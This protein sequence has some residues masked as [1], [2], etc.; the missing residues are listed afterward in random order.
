MDILIQAISF[1]IIIGV[2]VSVHEFGHFI[3][4]KWCGVGVLKFSIGFGRA[5]WKKTYKETVYQI[6]LIPLGGFVRM[7]GDMPDP[8]TTNKATDDLVREASGSKPSKLAQKNSEKEKKRQEEAEKELNDLSRAM[9]AD[10][11]CW[12][13]HQCFWKKFAIVSAG[14]IFNLIF[15]AIVFAFMGGIWGVQSPSEKAVIGKV[16]EGAPA[17]IA[18]LKENDKFISIAG[19]KVEKWEDAV[20]L[21]R[22]SEG[23]PIKVAVDRNGAILNLEI[24]PQKKELKDIFGKPSDI[25]LIGI[26]VKIERE[27]VPLWEALILGVKKTVVISQLTVIGIWKLITGELSAKE[28]LSGP[29]FI[30]KQ[31]G[32]EAKRG[33]ESFFGF[34]AI[35]SISL[36]IL[37]LLPIPV[38]DGG[39]LVFFILEKL[40]GG[41][42]PFKIKEYAQTVGF[43]LLMLLMSYVILNDI[44]NR[45]RDLEKETKIEWGERALN[46]K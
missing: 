30:F 20:R 10:E 33:L 4:A 1:L 25:Y 27:K 2:L 13:I 28:N 37:N 19:E 11:S 31:A 8:I 16:Q 17:E 46:D 38:L 29:I 32:A 23:E 41:E 44:R 45:S 9:I 35:L 7:V 14:P 42:L 36:G 21:I 34:M 39:H 12:F 24:T 26:E 3:V 22:A 43:F 6:A 5:I 18:G 15:A 40:K